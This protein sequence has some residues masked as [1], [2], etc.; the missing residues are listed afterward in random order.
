MAN[1]NRDIQIECGVLG[2]RAYDNSHFF[3][4]V[5]QTEFL[6]T[7]WCPFQSAPYSV[8]FTSKN[9]VLAF[10]S[11]IIPKYTQANNWLNLD[12]ICAVG[13]STAHFIKKTL[14][15]AFFQQNK[16]IFTPDGQNGLLPLIKQEKI[17][18]NSSLVYIFTSQIGKSFQIVDDMKDKCHFQCVVVPLYTLIEM[19]SDIKG[20]MAQSILKIEQNSNQK[21]VFYCRSGQILNRVVDLLIQLFQVDAAYKLP[22][23]I[24]F[25][26]WEQS[27][28]TALLELKLI[29]RKFS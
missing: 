20:T 28:N 1:K 16:E 23:Y 5:Y 11:Q 7:D 22:K 4:P 2:D 29:D 19:N 27:A 21:V 12:S 3:W 14:P 13:K 8:I 15:D 25:S 18:T 24:F 17:F 6:E 26:T 10:Q 9:A